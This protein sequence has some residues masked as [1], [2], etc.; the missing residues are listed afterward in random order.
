MDH[1][2]DHQQKDAVHAEETY[3]KSLQQQIKILELEID[4]LKKSGGEGK[5]QSVKGENVQE[6]EEK[7]KIL[8]VKSDLQTALAKFENVKLEK[9]KLQDRM[10]YLDKQRE[11]EKFKLME[12]ISR[13]TGRVEHLEKESED[14]EIRQ[15]SLLQVNSSALISCRDFVIFALMKEMEKQCIISKDREKSIQQ[16]SEELD[17]KKEEIGGCNVVTVVIVI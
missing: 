5:V 15:S 6:N 17:I 1:Q 4:Y 14:N 7:D 10:K 11:E 8:K 3:I 16:L 13:L 9:G 12:Q 2:Q